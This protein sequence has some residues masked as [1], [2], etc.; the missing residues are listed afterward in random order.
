MYKNE[1]LNNKA[2]FMWQDVLLTMQFASLVP[3]LEVLEKS[4]GV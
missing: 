3:A 2:K 4:G 1:R